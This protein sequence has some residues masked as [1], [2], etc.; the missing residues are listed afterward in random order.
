M[1]SRANNSLLIPEDAISGTIRALPRL[2]DFA[3]SR[4]KDLCVGAGYG[5]DTDVVV[6]TLRKLLDSCGD[7]SVRNGS[8]EWVSE[9]S[10]DNTPIEF[11]VA[12]AD[13][14][15][16]V[17]ALFEPQGEAPTVAAYRAAGLAFNARLERVFGADLGRFR[18][19][20]DLFLPE[21]MAGPFAVWSSA[22]FRRGREPAFKAYFN[23]NAQ[24]AD[25]AHELVY[26]ALHRLGLGRAWP[27]LSHHILARGAQL[28]ELK[29]FALDLSRDAHARVKVYVRHHAATPEDLEFASVPADSHVPGE[30]LDFVRAM[31]GGHARLNAR[32]A[33]TCS[34]FT[35]D[36]E[37]RPVATTVYVPVCAYARDDARVRQRVRDYL[38]AQGGDPTLYDSVL[39]SY[40]NRPL[41]A[42]VG[43]QSWVAMRRQDEQVRMTVYLATEANRVFEPGEI[44]APTGDY[45]TLVPPSPSPSQRASSGGGASCIE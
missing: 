28:D 44:P 22:V 29:Y 7:M 41:D 5:S 1:Q 39:A 40:A 42:G 18:D 16:E 3:T 12:M 2:V 33:F 15:A 13:G 36:A 8:S 9:I 23:P 32:A 21:H 45:S 31:R 35:G 6:G 34:S 26:E 19:V 30:A 20:Q 37:D 27:S 4:F 43:M 17:R 25:N 24:G 38:V 10:D 14:E 11:S